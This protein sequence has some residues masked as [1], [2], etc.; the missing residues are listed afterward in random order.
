M[1]PGG[2]SDRPNR[3]S[4]SAVASSKV[5]VRHAEGGCPVPP[6]TLDNDFG[7]TQDEPDK[8]CL[9]PA[10][11]V[12]QHP[13]QPGASVSVIFKSASPYAPKQ[14]ATPF[15]ASAVTVVSEGGGH[16]QDG[17]SFAYLKTLF[18][19][20]HQHQSACGMYGD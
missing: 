18:W 12:A 1:H 4:P 7:L 11:P 10:P 19:A 6:W 5:A 9:N 15:A 2:E 13:V 14:T 8:A 20:P 16:V 3:T 17:R